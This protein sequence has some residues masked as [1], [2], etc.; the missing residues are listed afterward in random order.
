MILLGGEACWIAGWGLNQYGDAS[1]V[2]RADLYSVGVN[3]LSQQYCIEKS[4]SVVS[5]QPDDI[6]IGAPDTTGNNLMDGGIGSCSGDS[7]GPLICNVN[8]VATLMGVSSRT[9]TGQCSS[10]GKPSFYTSISMD[11]WIETTIAANQI[12]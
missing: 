10:E 5:L 12:V 11:D 4:D 6:C 8:G 7:G 9:I 1:P 2:W 3:I